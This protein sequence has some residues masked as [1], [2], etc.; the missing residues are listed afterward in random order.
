M[1]NIQQTRYKYPRTFHFPESPGAMNDDRIL[2]P[3]ESY[4]K[5]DHEV[6]ITEKRDGENFSGYNDG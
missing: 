3:I 2:D 4:A 1:N 6:V 5:W